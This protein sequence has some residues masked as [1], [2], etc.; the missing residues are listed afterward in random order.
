MK[1]LYR[2][3]IMGTLIIGMNACHEETKAPTVSNDSA[4]EKMEK[5]MNVTP[6]KIWKANMETTQG[7]TKMYEMVSEFSDIENVEAYAE[8]KENLLVEYKLI[9]KNCTMKGEAH[10]QLHDYIMPFS[11]WFKG[12]SSNDLEKCKSSFTAIKTHLE[13]YSNR[14][15]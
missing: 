3:T 7:F 5:I 9:F 6:K 10:D 8:L 12:L 2:L 1:R 14:F 4:Q 13:D 15:E 11:N